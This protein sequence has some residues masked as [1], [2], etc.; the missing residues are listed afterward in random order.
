MRRI[1]STSEFSE[2]SIG[3][4]NGPN[5]I[6]DI[7]G[8]RP[9]GGTEIGRSPIGPSP[10]FPNAGDPAVRGGGIE[11]AVRELRERISAGPGTG[12]GGSPEPARTPAL[13]APGT[14]R[15]I[16]PLGGLTIMPDQEPDAVRRPLPGLAISKPITTVQT[17]PAVQTPPGLLNPKKGKKMGGLLRRASNIGATVSKG[18]SS[19][20][21]KMA[22]TA[23]GLGG[24]AVAASAANK[25]GFFDKAKQFL[26]APTMAQGGPSAPRGNFGMSGVQRP[27][28]RSPGQYGYK[29]RSPFNPMSP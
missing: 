24:V 26:G 17:G 9:I 3:I 1:L 11:S 6:G 4:D 22:L 16:T 15:I 27:A 18:L 29:H 10:A 5:R 21:G 8:P 12:P 13:P 23:V 2:D 20:L 28:Q 19:P 7:V 25:A 14:P